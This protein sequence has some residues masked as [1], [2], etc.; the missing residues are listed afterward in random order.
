MREER[1]FRLAYEAINLTAVYEHGHGWR[2][3]VVARRQD[4]QW[5]EAQLVEYSR[6]TTDE[7]ADVICV[8]ASDRLREG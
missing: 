5:D 1:L 8:E 3:R 4:E 6:L 2:L 7:L